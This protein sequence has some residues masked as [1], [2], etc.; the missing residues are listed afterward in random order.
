MLVLADFVNFDSVGE[1]ELLSPPPWD[2][3]TLEAEQRARVRAA[4]VETPLIPTLL[5][6]G[7]DSTRTLWLPDQL[8][9]PKSFA[10]TTGL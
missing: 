7:K 2:K 10:A 4:V 8:K 9:P 3:G 6:R 1:R 5:P